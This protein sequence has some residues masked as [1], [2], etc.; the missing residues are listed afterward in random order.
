MSSSV[1]HMVPVAEAIRGIFG[2]AAVGDKVLFC[3]ARQVLELPL[4]Q[5]EMRPMTMDDVRALFEAGAIDEE[6]LFRM[7]IRLMP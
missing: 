7:S 4:D 3:H 6:T 1:R 5:V 2:A